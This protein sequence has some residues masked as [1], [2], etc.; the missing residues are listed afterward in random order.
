MTEQA[1]I[2][3]EQAKRDAIL[4]KQLQQV[5]RKGTASRKTI[6][7]LWVNNMIRGCGPRPGANPYNGYCLSEVGTALLAKLEAAQ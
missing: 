5:D 6:D 4:R 1:F 3:T 7:M 2:S